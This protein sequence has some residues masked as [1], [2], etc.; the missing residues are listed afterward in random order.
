[1]ADRL[2]K[3]LVNR[4]PVEVNFEA[5]YSEYS[6]VE[7]NYNNEIEGG[8]TAIRTLV[9]PRWSNSSLIIWSIGVGHRDCLPFCYYWSLIISH[10]NIIVTVVN[11]VYNLTRNTATLLPSWATSCAHNY[12]CTYMTSH[13]PQQT[14]FV[15]E[16]GVCSAKIKVHST[17][18]K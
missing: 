13:I 18:I 14:L 6:K 1:M 16:V 5:E 4:D 7:A 9:E 2:A 15:R 3:S 10:T 8:R 11:L 17:L 12:V